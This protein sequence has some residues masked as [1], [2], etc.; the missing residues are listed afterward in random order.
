MDRTLYTID[1]DVGGTFT[2]GFF[3]DGEQVR[4]TKVL[5]TPHD[6]TEC[7]LTS[8]QKGGAAFNL[9]LRGL[10][11]RTS[12]ARLSTTLGTNT[13][14]Q[15]RG[16]KIGVLVTKGAERHFY[17]EGLA[18]LVPDFVSTE[19]V[20]SVPE[21]VD[22]GGKLAQEVERE[23]VLAAVRK[24]NGLGARMIAVSF[25]NAW[26]NPHNERRV[27]EILREH[28]PVHY[29]RSVPLQLGTDVVHVADDHARTNSVILNAYIHTDV[30]R[31]LY[32]VD[33]TLHLNGYDG[34]LLVV[35]S[36]GGNGRVAKTVA[37]N[38]LGSGPAVATR[39]AAKMSELLKLDRVITAD[40]GGTSLDTA[41][42]IDN[43]Y[44]LDVTPEVEG[45]PL[46]APM[47]A[48]ESIG[49]GGGTIA[50]VE[51]SVLAV[52]PESA[53][54][55]PGPVCYGKGGLE[56]TVTDADVVL[57][58]IDPDFF[59]NGQMRLD[60]VRARKAIERKVANPLG[61]EVEEAASLIRHAIN[62]DMADELE[63]F[64]RR[65]RHDPGEFVLFSIGGAGPLHACDVAAAVG[66]RS[67]VSF[68]FG[69]VFSAFGG[70]TTDVQHLYRR[71]FG[72]G[73]DRIDQIEADIAVLWGQSLQ[74]MVGEGFDTADVTIRAELDLLV[75]GERRVLRSTSQTGLRDLLAEQVPR[76]EGG[77]DV[78]I[79]DVRL[80]SQ[81]RVAHW[82][83]QA[84]PPGQ[85]SVETAHKGERAVLWG[86][87]AS[88]IPTPIF[89]R[90]RL[91]P[92]HDL[93]GPAIIEGPDTNYV[94]NP[95]WKLTVDKHMNLCMSPS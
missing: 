59:L 78:L 25:A 71:T 68:S 89:D 75:G 58:Y 84:K 53:G 57:G 42:L 52:G 11:R 83:P 72:L 50:K 15:R 69:S 12:V 62:A 34:P 32:R 61:I 24:L 18:R 8:M 41:I 51:D 3:T 40:M 14:V 63:Q 81:G 10:L 17:G 31:A 95:G 56:P 80:W 92:G 47:I 91:E 30:A 39:G 77:E 28:Y 7:V 33:D 88:M 6:I 44:A 66:L 55:A 70:S 48:V 65:Q 26:R 85:S 36:N 45:V 79:D 90:E 86:R 23:D 16:P 49:A 19:M 60:V 54:S 5:T 93:E 27:R 76:G 67:V 87:D 94:V 74:D 29:L 46:A 13:I 37:L 20:A 64:L 9:D 2:D 43:E 21:S 22:D 4:T 82:E 38:T 73:L 35:H 1:I